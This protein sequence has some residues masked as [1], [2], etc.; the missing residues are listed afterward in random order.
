MSKS[1]RRSLKWYL[2]LVLGSVS[3]TLL[4]AAAC[5]HAPDIDSTPFP[6]AEVGQTYTYAVHA[7]DP[8]GNAITYSLLQGPQ[9]M[10]YS[11]S[12]QR[13][14]WTP[15]ASQV[16]TTTVKV[17][18]KDS[19]GATD[20]Q[21]Y[22]LRVVADFCEIYPITI[23]Q[24]LLTTAQPGTSL[25]QIDRGTGPGNFSWLTWAGSTSAT[26]LATSLAPP[27]DSYNYV[28]PD[29]AGDRLLEIG[30]WA[31]GST[32]SMNSSAVRERMDALKTRDIVIPTW[33][34]VRG[35][36]SKFDYKVIRFATVR[37]LDYQ[38]NGQGWLKL[39]FQGYKNCYNDAPSSGPQSL[40]TP[41]DTALPLTLAGSD[42]ESD[43]LQYLV[44]SSPQHGQLTGSGSDLVYTPAPGYSGP[45]G[46]SYRTSDGEFDS[47]VSVVSIQVLPVDDPPQAADLSLSTDEDVPL[48]V[49]LQGADPEG[50]ALSYRIVQPP[51][52]GSLQGSG[53][54]LTYV[55]EAEWN[56]SD[57]FTY[58]ANDGVQDSPAATAN[59]V[60]RP[61]NDAPTA[62]AQQVQTD[63]DVALPIRLTGTDP[64]GEPLS[65]RIVGQP[66]HG[67]LT[68][69]GDDWVY[70]PEHNFA[71]EDSF[72]FVVNDGSVDSAVATVHIAVIER[73]AAP[74]A[75]ELSY[76]VRAGASLSISLAAQDP[77]GDAISYRVTS[78]PGHGELGGDAP[79]LHFLAEPG[80]AGTLDFS[81]VANDGRLDS[82]P[83]TVSIRV[84]PANPPKFTTV[85]A[86]FV[87]ERMEYEYD[88]DAFDPDEGDELSFSLD[89]SVDGGLI[90]EGS[91]IV[92]WQ[93]PSWVQAGGVRDVNRACKT[94]APPSTFDPVL[95]WGRSGPE[96]GSDL[97]TVFG[98]PLVGQLSDDNGDGRIDA[99]DR[100]GH[101][102]RHQQQRCD[103]CA[104][105]R[106]GPDAMANPPS[107]PCGPRDACDWRHRRRWQDGDCRGQRA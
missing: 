67:Q 2:G 97:N 14:E 27:G 33:T 101:V 59:I 94:P 25:G 52:H 104:Q 93:P 78:L 71:G 30:D 44:V 105:W 102:R 41:E 12:A 50:S 55:P 19:W 35:Q 21:S 65:F 88:A 53:A 23:P 20:Q 36:G 7:T 24:Q 70:A 72:G 49:T 47:A 107:I 3:A 28:N 85:P 58:V 45:D 37:L 89:R 98:P 4:A 96:A 61:V 79:D 77:D 39:K 17:Q 10:A 43:A 34:S 84:L 68:G 62:H 99:G 74:V 46:F 40:T 66:M 82:P 15:T 76:E 91:G 87:D 16:G 63:E 57:S 5:N 9:G 8:D 73:N 48:P 95:K 100:A 92:R 64:E 86:N 106:Y 31:Q 22:S 6:V 60:V 83:A 29:N 81:Y 80:F 26:T 38:L 13:V 90:K 69:A 11:T 42:P 56:G 51:M 54:T 75:Q 18:A 103:D 32:G 1:A